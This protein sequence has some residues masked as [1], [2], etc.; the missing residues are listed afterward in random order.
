MSSN[1]RA[2]IRYTNRDGGEIFADPNFL[3]DGYT[4]LSLETHHTIR[5]LAEAIVP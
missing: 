5:F 3:S 2:A 4:M 1:H